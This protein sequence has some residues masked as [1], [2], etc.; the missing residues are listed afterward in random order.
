MT[1]WPDIVD[2]PLPI[3]IETTEEL[4]RERSQDFA[5][6]IAAHREGIRHAKANRDNVIALLTGKF[7]HGRSL[8]EKTFDDYMPA[9]T[10]RCE[11]IQSNSPD[12]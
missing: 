2:D 10:R 4:W 3:S 8:A 12:Y 5:A 7:G 1:A 11:S 9:W 6:F